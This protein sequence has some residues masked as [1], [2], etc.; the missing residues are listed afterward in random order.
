MR[1]DPKSRPLQQSSHE[2]APMQCVSNTAMQYVSNAP[3]QYVSTAN[4][5]HAN[6]HSGNANND[7]GNAN[8]DSEYANEYQNDMLG[9]MRKQNEITTLLIQQQCMSSLP[10]REVLIFDGDPLKYHAF[11]KAFENGVENNTRISVIVYI[12][13]SST[14]KVF[15]WNW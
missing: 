8:V 10:K 9:I 3:M 15:L 7:S 11:M 1:S 5:Y 4:T 14:Q 13:W 6:V 12:T 2:Y